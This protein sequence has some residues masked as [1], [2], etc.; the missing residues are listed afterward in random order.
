M[1]DIVALFDVINILSSGKAGGR[2][3]ILGSFPFHAAGFSVLGYQVVK[4]AHWLSGNGLGD[5]YCPEL[6]SF[7]RNSV[8]FGPAT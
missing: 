4:F 6:R 5:P 8:Q 1:S 2:E 3:L 7:L